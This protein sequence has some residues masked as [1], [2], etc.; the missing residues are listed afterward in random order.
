[1]ALDKAANVPRSVPELLEAM[2]AGFAPKFLFFWGHT[3]R[4]GEL[5][6]ECLSQWYPAPFAV[7]GVSFATAEHF[8]MY[9]KALLFGDEPCAER[10]LGA[11]TPAEAKEL[12]RAVK[13]F[14]DDRWKEA[15]FEI[16]TAGSLAKFSQ[17]PALREFLLGTKQRVLVEASPRDQIW[18][19]GLGESNEAAHDP[20]RW[21][22][23]NLLG[24]ALMQARAAIAREIK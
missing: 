8:M 15:R 6:K 5:G 14:D 10:I 11:R 24:F 21:R 13:G 20:A 12:G 9:R 3:A 16:V 2:G 23:L 4:G 17:S 7:S 18:G 1:M 22:G 19:I